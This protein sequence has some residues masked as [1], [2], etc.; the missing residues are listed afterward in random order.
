MKSEVSVRRNVNNTT[1]ICTTRKDAMEN[2]QP[3]GRTER[4]KDVQ[5]DV[6]KDMQKECLR[7]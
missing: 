3:P 7:E 4:L 1:R 5:R 2:L 6:L